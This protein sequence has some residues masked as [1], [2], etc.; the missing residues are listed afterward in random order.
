MAMSR[1]RLLFKVMI[2]GIILG[3]WVNKLLPTSSETEGVV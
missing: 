2:Y 1:R 3:S